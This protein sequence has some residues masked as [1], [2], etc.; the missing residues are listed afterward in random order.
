MKTILPLT[1]IPIE[2]DGFHLSVKIMING[3]EANLIVDTGASRTVFDE[4]R[5]VRF[6]G[7]DNLEEQ[8]R[9]SSGL[10]TTT[11]ASKKVTIDKLLLNTIEIVNYEATI[12]DLQHVNQ[13]YEKLGLELVDGIL[14]GDILFDYKAV[15][16]YNRK[17]LLLEGE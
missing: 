11:M 9:L 14:G 5:I 1:I 12:L 8:E 2:D 13:S 7:H 6:L 3:E 16:D 4:S 15:I 10:G 17:E